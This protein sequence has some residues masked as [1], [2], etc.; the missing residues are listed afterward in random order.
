MPAILHPFS[1]SPV[2]IWLRN[3]SC[4]A[5]RRS[6]QASPSLQ[7]RAESAPRFQ[8]RM[9]KN[10]KIQMRVSLLKCQGE[11]FCCGKNSQSDP[12]S[13]ASPPTP[14]KMQKQSGGEG[15]RPLAFAEAPARCRIA[16]M[17]GTASQVMTSMYSMYPLNDVKF[18]PRTDFQFP[19]LYRVVFSM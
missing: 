12:W 9:L 17:S 4:L 6:S 11:R 1:N 19:A 14:R 15:H 3:W 10:M 7:Q 18:T 2:L 16:A 5:R 13:L 8:L